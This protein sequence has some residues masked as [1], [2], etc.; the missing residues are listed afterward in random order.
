M[1]VLVRLSCLRSGTRL[2]GKSALRLVFSTT[3]RADL[4]QNQGTTVLARPVISGDGRDARRPVVNLK[5][6]MS[7]SRMVCF[8]GSPG[9]DW[10]MRVFGEVETLAS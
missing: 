2:I 8:I 1:K 7:P 9:V 4:R 5:N 10:L 3:V 6:K